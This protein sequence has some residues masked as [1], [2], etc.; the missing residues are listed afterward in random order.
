MN[1]GF[2][3]DEVIA[4]TA[5]MALNHLNEVFECYYEFDALRSFQFSENFFSDKKVEQDAV[6]ECLIW[7][8]SDE[9]MMYKVKPYKEAVKALTLLKHQGH[10]IFIV[11]KRPSSMKSMTAEWL[12]VNDIPFNKLIHTN[13]KP[14]SEYTLKYSLD[15]FVDDLESNLLDLYKNQARWK[16]GLML[17]T[18]PWNENDYIDRSKFIRVNNWT[19]V[20]KGVDIGNRL[21]ERK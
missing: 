7:A 13:H 15:C 2:D 19:D 10:K 8:V 21:K 11:T 9:K 4:Q 14:K 18:K 20:L 16:K 12:K 1:L 5:Q 3:L 17:M 6:V